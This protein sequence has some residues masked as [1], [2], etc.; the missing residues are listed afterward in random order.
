MWNW[1]KEKLGIIALEVQQERASKAIRRIEGKLGIRKLP[2][3]YDEI[4]RARS[5]RRKSGNA[6]RHRRS[7]VEPV[8]TSL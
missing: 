5:R 1:L 7:P 2:Q 6:P 3:R 4:E 8:E